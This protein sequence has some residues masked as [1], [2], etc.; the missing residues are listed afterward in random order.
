MTT[1]NATLV[2]QLRDRTG[3]GVIDCK[4]A[5]TETQGDLEAAVDRL[6]AAEMAKAA[7]KVDPCGG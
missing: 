7:K 5:L 3:A 4:K 1:I 2:K 6:R